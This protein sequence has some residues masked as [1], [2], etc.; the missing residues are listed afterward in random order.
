MLSRFFFLHNFFFFKVISN[1]CPVF[2]R[3][4]YNDLFEQDYR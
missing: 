2:N 3:P 4:H 1:F